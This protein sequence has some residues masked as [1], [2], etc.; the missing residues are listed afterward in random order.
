MPIEV[1]KMS[2]S[3]EILSQQSEPTA[4]FSSSSSSEDD[5]GCTLSST[6]QEQFE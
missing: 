2:L 5:D 4:T 3:Q 1:L 6:R